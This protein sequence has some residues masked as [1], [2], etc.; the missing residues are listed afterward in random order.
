[1]AQGLDL[2]EVAAQAKP[3]VARILEFKKFLY[4]ENKKEQAAKKRAKD[5]EL[6]ELWLTPRIADHDLHTRLRRVEEFL[7]EGNKIMLRVKFKGREMA[8]QEL[9]RELLDKTLQILGDKVMIEREPKFEG[10]SITVIIGRNRNT[11]P[12]PTQPA[13]QA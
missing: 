9:G 2:V 8:H 11:K 1:M 4:E 3:P 6:K 10:R 5:V 7:E 12:A 13:A